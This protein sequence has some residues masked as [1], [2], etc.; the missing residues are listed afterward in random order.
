[1]EEHPQINSSN[2]HPDDFQISEMLR[3]FKQSVVQNRFY[4]AFGG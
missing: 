3:T 4:T 1:M 2:G